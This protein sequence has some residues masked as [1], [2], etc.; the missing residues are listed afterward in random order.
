MSAGMYEHRTGQLTSHHWCRFLYWDSAVNALV[1]TSLMTLIEINRPALCFLRALFCRTVL[2]LCEM[3]QTRDSFFFSSPPSWNLFPSMDKLLMGVFEYF[4]DG[5]HFKTKT[6]QQKTNLKSVDVR[7]S[8]CV[9]A[10]R[11]WI[12]EASRT[13]CVSTAVVFL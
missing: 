10:A 12:S 2:P 11:Q 6:L 4:K 5:H 9:C 7:L 13:F 8:C 1:C 3:M